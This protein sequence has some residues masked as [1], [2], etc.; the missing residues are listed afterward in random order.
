MPGPPDVDAADRHVVIGAGPAGLTAARELVRLGRPVLVLEADPTY[1]GGIAR[2]VEYKGNRFDMGGHR[3][4][5]KSGPINDLWDEMLPGGFLQV[6]RLSR[7]YYDRR[8]FQYP[9]EVFEA[10]S[11]LG[12][13]RATRIAASYLRAKLRPVRPEES[14]ED[15]V[16]NRF[17]RELYETFFRSYTEKVWGI[18][19]RDINKDF[20]AQRIR[21][22]SMWRV[23]RTAVARTRPDPGIKTLITTFK[24]PRH[25][26]GELWEAV[27]DDV[28]ARGGQ[29][30]MG[31]QVV[32]IRHHDGKVTAVETADGHTVGGAEFYSTMPLRDLVRALAP[33][34]PP[35]V[36]DAAARLTFRD[37][38]T[39]ALVVRRPDVFPDNWIYVHE[40]D[41]A[42]GRIQNYKNWSPHMVADPATT[43][44]GM[45][46]FCT[47]GDDVWA[48][49]DDAL[50]EL[51]A[52]ELDDIGLARKDD[53]VDGTVVRVPDAYPVYDAG[54]RER[55]Q[56]VQDWLNATFTNLHPAGRGGLHNYNSQDHS[57]MAGLLQARGADDGRRYDVWALN[58]DEE[59]AEEGSPDAGLEARLVARPLPGRG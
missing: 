18:P 21:D 26:P 28:V 12:P 10:L 20:A 30:A 11:K 13:R 8:Y 50:V 46:Y 15:W 56:V 40:P 23:L 16:V 58:T 4:Y 34:A 19:C 7:I 39:V 5:S 42:V 51:A 31:R 9:I 25:G 36:A 1:V 52:R 47:R 24:Y 2:T 33:E 29:V 35:A 32:R 59:Y 41:V 48:M 45:E 43:C 49:A 6:P 22:L 14:V 37:F 44:L 38:L 57:M 17:G 54:Y 27:R 53:C 3:F 55:R